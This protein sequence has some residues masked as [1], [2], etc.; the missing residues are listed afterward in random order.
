VK[1][2]GGCIKKVITDRYC[3]SLAGEGCGQD[4]LGMNTRIS[5][6]ESNCSPMKGRN[7]T[8]T[9]K[10]TINNQNA[11]HLFLHLFCFK[12]SFILTKCS[13]KTKSH[14]STIY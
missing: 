1:Q 5:V 14:R 10:S 2:K 6:R 11:K 12:L 4:S 8:K 13:C 7:K 9:K 3:Y